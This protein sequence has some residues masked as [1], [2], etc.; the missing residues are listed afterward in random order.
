MNSWLN[1]KFP[2]TSSGSSVSIPDP[3]SVSW[4]AGGWLFVSHFL[5]LCQADTNSS[6]SQGHYESP[7]SQ[8][9]ES[10]EGAWLI[11]TSF[12]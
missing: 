3:L 2:K 11:T 5:H 8:F 10:G 6:P 4:A 9:M 12:H 1:A 7:Q